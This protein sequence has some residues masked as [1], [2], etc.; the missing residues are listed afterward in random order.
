M[1]NW[2]AMAEP[3]RIVTQRRMTISVIEGRIA[4]RVFIKLVSLGK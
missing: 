2:R 1:N 4:T 3:M